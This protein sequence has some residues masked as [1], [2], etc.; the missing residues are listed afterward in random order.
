M[1]KHAVTRSP[2]AL[3]EP[4][5]VGELELA[6]RIVMAP[7]TRSRAM[8]GNVPGPLTAEY[9]AQRAS[10]GL[11]VAEATQ[12]SAAAQ[13]YANTPGVHT[14]EQV[15]GWRRVTDAVHARGGRIALQIWH[16]GRISHKV[17]Q[18]DGRAPGAPSAVQANNVKTFIEG[19]GPVPTAVPRALALHEIP[20]I[21]EDFRQS[22]RRAIEAGFDAV[23]IHGANGYLI[24]QFLR[25]ESN[26]RTDEY[27]GSIENRTR[28]MFEIAQA[29]AGEIG[30]GRTGI[31]I[32][33]V[34]PA[35]GAHD[36][37]PQ[38]LFEHAVERLNGLGLAYLHVIEGAT[39]GPRDI[40][41]FDFAALRRRF[42]GAWIGNNGYTRE[43]ALQAVAAGTVD[44]VAFGRPYIFNPDLVRRLRED[45]PLNQ[46]FEDVALYG[47][48]GAHGYTDYP[49]LDEAA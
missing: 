41:P 20:G 17:F 28:L 30:A 36:S 16:T 42:D 18:P 24:D 38:P 27:G 8:Q 25:D 2:E 9:Y 15:A 37:N 34:S 44:L 43:L 14:A 31:R 3:F 11:I 49:T 32:S 45:A 48:G 12:V 29:V 39:G 35:N 19:R 23:E 4:T 40:A 47:G 46:K 5:R 7:L 26:R 1:S 10:A 22:A 33:P 6:N 13:G 21:V